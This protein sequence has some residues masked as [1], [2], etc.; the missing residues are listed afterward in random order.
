MSIF[1]NILLGVDLAQCRPLSTSGFSAVAREAIRQAIHMARLNSAS[2]L[3]LSAANITEDVLHP[4]AEEDRSQ[5]SASLRAAGGK[6]LDDL[7]REASD[8]GVQATGKMVAGKGWSE[9]VRQVLRGKHDLVVVGTRNLTGLRRMLFGNTAMKLLRRCPCPV[10]V[11]K[12]GTDVTRLNILVTTDFTATSDDAVRLAISLAEQ[13]NSWLDILHVVE[14]P[15]DRL[16]SSGLADAKEK[17][18]HKT[19][20]ANADRIMKEHLEQTDYRAL[21][22]RVRIH[23]ADGVGIPDVAIQTFIQVHGIHLLVMGTIGRG[24]LPGIMIGNTA[25]RLLPEVH[26][27]V[28]AIK[29]RDFVCPMKLEE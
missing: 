1:N 27:S 28:L 10:L 15:L 11:A 26:C 21:G 24:G 17:Q 18:Y 2:L 9:I 16:W 25:E 12:V 29:P 14:Y 3:I 22:G 19:I 7:V 6:V 4:L 23:L 13:T 5:V 8:E 20:R